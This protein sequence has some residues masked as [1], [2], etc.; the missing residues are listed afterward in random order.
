ME[1]PADRQRVSDVLQEA[2]RQKDKAQT[3]ILKI[4]ELGLVEM[5]R[6]R[7]RESLQQLLCS[8]C[9]HCDGTGQAKSAETISFEILRKVERG[10]T[11]P[12]G[13][14][15]L[16]V[17]ASPAVAAFLSDSESRAL[18]QLEKAIAKRII[19][20]AQEGFRTTQYEIVAQ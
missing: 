5:T 17:K 7:A 8:P 6:K 15:R 4:S 3:R 19:I 2:V 20:K 14:S 18:D 16:V 9:P 13:S 10:E 1:N 11:F 12:D